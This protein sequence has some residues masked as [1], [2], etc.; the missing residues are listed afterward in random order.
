[1]PSADSKK[2]TRVLHSSKEVQRQLLSHPISSGFAVFF[3][4]CTHNSAGDSTARP[5][6]SLETLLIVTVAGRGRYRVGKSSG[7]V[8]KGDILLVQAGIPHAYWC[9]S[10]DWSYYW[11]HLVGT[12]V[13]KYTVQAGGE[14]PLLRISPSRLQT[15]VNEFE[16]TIKEVTNSRS[17]ERMILA[18]HTMR[19]ILAKAMFPSN[20]K[21]MNATRATT[22]HALEKSLQFLLENTRR[23]ITLR[24]LANNVGL[25]PS[26]LANLFKSQT[27]T[28]P[29]AHH[30]HLRV[31]EAAGLLASTDLHIKEV[32]SRMGFH[33]PY[34]F[35]R[36]FKSHLQISPSGYR[37]RLAQKS[38]S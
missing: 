17:L 28:S 23:A 6:G 38:D 16:F 1:M 35:S 3:L 11:A 21:Q 4:G 13:L 19:N 18:S 30:M 32:S 25:S 15:I 5:S 20:A 33:D 9:E 24:E 34:Y 8:R 37:K 22:H 12:D 14:V 7:A 27:G 31:Q 10:Q 2:E 29:M 26:R 36:A